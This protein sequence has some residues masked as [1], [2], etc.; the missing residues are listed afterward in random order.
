MDENA[1]IALVNSYLQPALSAVMVI[2]PIAAA[3][4]CG[5][6]TLKWYASDQQEQQQNPIGPKIKKAV[7]IAV[8]MFPITA[9]LKIFGVQ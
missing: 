6:A 1:L 5:V 4:Y 9:I 7:L 8:V 3:L 2:I